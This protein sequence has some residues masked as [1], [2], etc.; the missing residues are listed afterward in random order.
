MIKPHC[1]N[2]PTVNIPILWPTSNF[3]LCETGV[4]SFQ[5]ICQVITTL[6]PVILFSDLLH[7]VHAFIYFCVGFF[8]RVVISCLIVVK[9]KLNLIYLYT[10]GVFTIKTINVIVFAAMPSGCT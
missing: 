7:F 8:L 4:L 9:I 5:I 1:Y 3:V 10:A 2:I 6:F